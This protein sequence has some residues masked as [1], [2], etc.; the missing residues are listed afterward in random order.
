MDDLQVL[1]ESQVITCWLWLLEAG[2]RY[3]VPG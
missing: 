3:L 2:T 1:Q